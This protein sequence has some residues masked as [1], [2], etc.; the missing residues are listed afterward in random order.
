MNVH[1]KNVSEV[2]VFLI[3]VRDILAGSLIGNFK[4]FCVERYLKEYVSIPF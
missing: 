1:I 2:R 4:A 3:S